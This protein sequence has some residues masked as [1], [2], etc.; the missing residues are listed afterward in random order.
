MK[1][2]KAFGEGRSLSDAFAVPAQ[3]PA[4]ELGFEPSIAAKQSFGSLVGERR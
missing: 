4:P 1:K 2:D 3:V